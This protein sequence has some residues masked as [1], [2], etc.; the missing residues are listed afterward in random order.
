MLI[1][2]V[3][4]KKYLEDRA[5]PPMG[6]QI[7]YGDAEKV[8]EA[9][10][11]ISKAN[12]ESKSIKEELM[13]RFEELRQNPNDETSFNKFSEAYDRYRDSL[14]KILYQ[15]GMFEG[16]FSP[17]VHGVCDLALKILKSVYPETSNIHEKLPSI[18]TYQNKKKD[19]EY[20]L[21]FV[22]K[23]FAKVLV[24]YIKSNRVEYSD[25]SFTPKQ[26]Q[27]KCDSRAELKHATLSK[28]MFNY[29]I[30]KWYSWDPRLAI[31]LKSDL[32]FLIKQ[33]K[34][35]IEPKVQVKRKKKNKIIETPSMALIKKDHSK[36]IKSLYSENQ[37][38]LDSVISNWQTIKSILEI[39][40]NNHHDFK[41]VFSNDRDVNKRT[42]EYLTYLNNEFLGMQREDIK[43]ALTAF[44]ETIKEQYTKNLCN[45]IYLM[46]RIIEPDVAIRLLN[47][48]KI[49][50][51][52]L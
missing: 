15:S 21:N 41:S 24:T 28:K 6:K 46:H 27:F 44:P 34:S 49:A 7:Q 16:L 2:S 12:P 50:S 11:F 42:L 45:L 52:M 51:L 40:A 5:P 20:H 36:L 1:G 37:G 22:L 30:S 3:E 48:N 8:T 43:N 14:S 25:G 29:N 4:L 26:Y 47:T 23:A 13:G 32:G 39:I 35:S 33:E 17:A 31:D 18:L 9:I 19:P 10:K 38:I